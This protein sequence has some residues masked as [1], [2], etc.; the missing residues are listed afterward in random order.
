MVAIDL[1]RFC[2][3]IDYV[4]TDIA[5]LKQALTHCSAGSEN[6]ERYEFLGD[7]ILNFVITQTLFMRY[8][9]QNEGQLSRLRAFLVKG[10]MLAEI[11]TE[12][13]LGD[14]LYLGQG[15]LKTGGFGRILYH[16]FS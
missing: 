11:A 12:I 4:F 13:E 14:Y 15:E 8:T 10:E 2:R 16:D 1:H 3:R 9:K 5:F 6:N 7:S